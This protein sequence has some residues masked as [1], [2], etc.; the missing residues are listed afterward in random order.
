MTGKEKTCVH[1]LDS[2]H[3]K[4]QFQFSDRH[5]MSQITDV[6]GGERGQS[7]NEL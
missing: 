2:P 1:T 7:G 3:K 4:L 6:S 5:K